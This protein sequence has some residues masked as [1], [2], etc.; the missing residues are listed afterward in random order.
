MSKHREVTA[1]YL[2]PTTDCLFF[3]NRQVKWTRYAANLGV[4]LGLS[5]RPQVNKSTKAVIPYIV[6]NVTLQETLLW[7]TWRVLSRMCPLYSTERPCR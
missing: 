1:I 3:A 7:K 5:M 6:R 4:V 2:A